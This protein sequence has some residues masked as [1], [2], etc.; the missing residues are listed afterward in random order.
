MSYEPEQIAA[1]TLTH[2]NFAFALISS[3]F[4]VIE[5]T[6]GDSDLWRRTTALKEGRP[7]LKV[8]LSIG[9]HRVSID[10]KCAH[11]HFLLCALGGWTFN[12][13]PT[14]NIFSDMVGSTANTNT[15]I[16]SVL[17]VMETYAFDGIDVDWEVGQ[18]LLSF[19]WYCNI[20][21]IYLVPRCLGSR[22]YSC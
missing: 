13:K 6:K 1:D 9:T 17:S 18:L 20:S 16:R 7:A 19:S 8:F 14:Q 15:F 10:R 11:S 12:D 22:W 3:T 5:M 21:W 4:E 2:I